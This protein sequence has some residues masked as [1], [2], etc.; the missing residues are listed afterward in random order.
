MIERRNF[1]CNNPRD[2]KARMSAANI[3][4]HYFLI[5]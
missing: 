3:S 5:G 2:C 4:N 1:A